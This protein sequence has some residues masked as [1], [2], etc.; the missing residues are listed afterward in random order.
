[1][2]DYMLSVMLAGIVLKL[3]LQ[4]SGIMKNKLIFNLSESNVFSN[5]R[6]VE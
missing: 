5:C 4:L 2:E 3:K 6:G 1:M